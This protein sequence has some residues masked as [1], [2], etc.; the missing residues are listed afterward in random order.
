MKKIN[1]KNKDGKFEID[2]SPEVKNKN[3]GTIIENYLSFVDDILEK[4][5]EL[6]HVRTNK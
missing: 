6:K 3:D 1:M 2:L 5:E 4:Y